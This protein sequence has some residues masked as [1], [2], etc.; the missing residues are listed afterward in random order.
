MTKS[1]KIDEGSTRPIKWFFEPTRF[2][3]RY[4]L[5]NLGAYRTWGGRYPEDRDAYWRVMKELAVLL[6]AK[7]H[8]GQKVKATEVDNQVQ[9]AVTLEVHMTGEQTRNWLRNKAAALDEFHRYRVR[10]G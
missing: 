10:H 1:P 6:S 4:I 7:K 9:W 5:K 8:L 3:Y 2:M